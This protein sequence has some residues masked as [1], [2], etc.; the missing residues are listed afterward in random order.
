MTFFKDKHVGNGI[1][2]LFVKKKEE[3]VRKVKKSVWE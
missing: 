1:S 2:D 3:K